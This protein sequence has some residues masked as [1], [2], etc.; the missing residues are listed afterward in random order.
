[1]RI[2]AIAIIVVS[3]ATASNCFAFMYSVSGN[4]PQSPANYTR[5]P[6]LIDLINQ[7]TRQ[8][9]VWCNG[10]ESFSYSGDTASLNMALQLYAKV[11]CP[12][13]TVVLRPGPLNKKIDWEVHIVEGIVR[14]GIETYGLQLVRDLDPTFVIYVSDRIDL[15]KM[16]IPAGVRILQIEDLRARYTRAL[17]IG[18]DPTKIEA[19]A[20]LKALENDPVLKSI[21]NE[22]YEMRLGQIEEFVDRSAK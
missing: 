12:T 10:A 21:G 17:Q 9:L 14:A 19:E 6:G 1:M 15:V 11:K 5:W 16:V 2:F 13:Y 20:H 3:V 7:P 22:E 8:Q 4:K 18:N